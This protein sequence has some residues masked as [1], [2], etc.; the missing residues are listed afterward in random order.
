MRVPIEK[1]KIKTDFREEREGLGDLALSIRKVGLLQPILVEEDDGD[2]VV[3]VGR[4]RLIALRDYIGLDALEEGV[5]FVVRS[6]IDELVAQLEENIQRNDFKP[7]EV[8]RLVVAI[9]ER[10]VAEFGR[11]VRGHPEGWSI[12]DTAKLLG[13]DKTFVSRMMKIADHEDIVKDCDSVASAISAVKRAEEERVLARVQK[14]RAK[15]VSQ[16]DLKDFLSNYVC[17]DVLTYLPTIPD[18]SID[19]ILTDPPY[20]I[21]LD[22]VATSFKVYDDDLADVISLLEAC[23]PHFRRVIRPGKYAVIWTSFDLFHAVCDM[24]ERAGFYVPR[25]PLVWV[26][27]GAT[28]RSTQAKTRVGC[29]AEIAAY[30]Y[31]SPDAILSKVGRSNIFHF[32][33]ISPDKKFHVAQKPEA[34]LADMIQTFSVKGDVVLDVFAGSASVARACWI[35]KRQFSGCELNEEYYNE[36]ITFTEDWIREEECN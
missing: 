9:H 20:G 4:S 24:L 34:L 26:K 3:K 17:A 33:S 25:V 11:P 2:Y 32:P 27:S 29:A 22:E 5:H 10:G 15:K 19:M 31:S 35:T 13:K 36:G 23:I 30:A 8:A 16:G 7:I 12:A 6:D 28:G 1:F 14:E 18:E 21:N